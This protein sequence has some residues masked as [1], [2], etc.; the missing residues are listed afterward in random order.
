MLSGQNAK[1]WLPTRPEVSEGLPGGFPE[2]VFSD[3][4]LQ[5]I[6]AQME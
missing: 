2:F 5:G 6:I 3:R 1:E 4:Q